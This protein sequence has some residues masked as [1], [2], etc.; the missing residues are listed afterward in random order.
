MDQPPPRGIPVWSARQVAYA[1]LFVVGVLLS[2]WLLY[3]FSRVIFILFIAIVLGTAIRPVVEWLKR[4]GVPRSTGVLLV[5]LALLSVMVGVV[6]SVLPIV[7]DQVTAISVDL[8]DYYNEFRN[9]IFQSKSRILQRIAVQ[10]PPVLSLAPGAPQQPAGE[11]QAIDPLAGVNQF[12]SYAGTFTRGAL[13]L[14]AVFLLGFYWTLESE[15]TIRSLLLW[16]P[17][18]RRDEVRELIAQVE[19]KVGGFILGQ[20]LLCLAIG[21]LALIAYVVIGL[22]YALV[23]AILAGILEAV[24]VLGP[25]LGAIPA[26]LVALSVDPTKALWV[27]IAAALIQQ[28]ENYLL[29]PRVMNRSVGVSPFVTLLALAAFT[30]LLGL[31]GAVMAVPMAAIIQLLIDRFVFQATSEEGLQPAGRGQIS[32]LQYEAQDLQQ[33]MRKQFREKDGQVD[34]IED[35]LEAIAAELDRLLARAAQETE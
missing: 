23:L 32:V 7:V 9:E 5:Y 25:V 16:L 35:S 31:A 2:F 20:S 6:V 13:I 15:R 29:V 21:V 34:E 26:I 24:P 1:T 10:L 11:A 19:A 12:L 33:D 18:N 4:H 3:R 17:I 28:A 30:S 22:P 8:P 14:V 27:V